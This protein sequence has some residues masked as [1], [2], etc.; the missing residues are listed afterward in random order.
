MNVQIAL[1][2]CL[3]AV[4]GLLITTLD[5]HQD[6][7]EQHIAVIDVNM[8]RIDRELRTIRKNLSPIEGGMTAAGAAHLAV[9]ALD[10][11]AE[12]ATDVA[13]AENIIDCI[14]DEGC[15]SEID[16][17]LRKERGL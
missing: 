6:E 17:R 9:E 2:F 11:E 3:L 1:A 5:S 16:R 4:T 13:S 8:E 10:S 14:V 7:V 15:W 12:G